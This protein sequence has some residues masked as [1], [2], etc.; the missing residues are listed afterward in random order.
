[1]RNVSSIT[2]ALS[3]CA[4]MRTDSSSSFAHER[5]S[6][7]QLRRSCLTTGHA[8]NCTGRDALLRASGQ[9]FQD[10]VLDSLTIAPG[11]QGQRY[12]QSGEDQ[13]T[14]PGQLLSMGTQPHRGDH[15][16]QTADGADRDQRKQGQRR[17]TGDEA[18]NVIRQTG[19]IPEE[20]TRPRFSARRS[21]FSNAA[22]AIRRCTNGRPR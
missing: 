4:K 14:L 5:R 16:R 21:I 19:T 8:P 3:A 17:Q 7:S 1:M 12:R 6:T 20:K 18:G 9:P 15:R 22:G 10:R 13:P 11:G 2:G